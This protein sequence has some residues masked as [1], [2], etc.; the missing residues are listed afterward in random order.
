VGDGVAPRRRMDGSPV[1]SPSGV[2]GRG[3]DGT[4]TTRRRRR[5]PWRGYGKRAS[6]GDRATRRGGVTQASLSPSA[7]RPSNSHGQLG[8]RW[9]SHPCRIIDTSTIM[10]NHETQ[11]RRRIARRRQP[12]TPSRAHAPGHARSRD[13]RHRPNP[14]RGAQPALR[15]ARSRS[16][17][18]RRLET[19]PRQHGPVRS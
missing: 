6:P 16:K 10:V 1:G 19:W 5:S 2:F 18:S 13:G 3:R 15:A 11:T 12:S 9:L 4:W 17:A 8:Y 7:A 14:T